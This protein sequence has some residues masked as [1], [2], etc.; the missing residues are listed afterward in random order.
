[1][2][3]QPRSPSI[4]D[5][6]ALANVSYQTVSR[7]L[8]DHPN[9]RASTR[10]KVQAAITQLGYSPNSAARTLVTGRSRV[11]GVITLDVANVDGLAA[12]YGVE[13]RARE[14][15]YF[16]STVALEH[17]DRSSMRAAVD[18][19]AEQRVAGMLVIVP[20]E[21]A[22]DALTSLP[23]SVPLVLIEGRPGHGIANAAVD[24]ELGARR[25]TEH[26]LELGHETVF[27]V[28]GLSDWM[29]THDRVTGWR[30]ALEAAGREAPLPLAGDWTAGS[31]YSAGRMLARIPEL[32]AVFASNDDMAL[33]ILLALAERG[34]RVPED[35]S[36]VGFDN[37][38]ASA[39]YN[40][41]LTTVQQEFTA[42][43]SRAVE[44]L[45]GQIERGERDYEQFLIEPQLVVRKSTGPARTA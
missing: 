36:V 29:Q 6:A 25:A 1:M 2:S 18:Q 12:M 16:V 28:R 38:D 3:S 32:T 17:V 21:A 19:L 9:V 37:L 11:L 45:F 4:N 24:Q 13:R 34:L 23:S 33:G 27:H 44:M 31:G 10:L 15:G 43:G 41:P 40:P 8:N 20:S 30:K 14:H 39:Y 42:V 5:V 26:L 35:V 22:D 7:V